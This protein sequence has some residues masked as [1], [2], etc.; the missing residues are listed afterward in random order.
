MPVTA[1][2]QAEYWEPAEEGFVLCRLCP[3]GCRI[4]PSS[5]G[6]CGARQ[7]L[8]GVL[9]AATYGVLSASHVD[10][11]EKKP[12]WHYYPGREILSVGSWGCNL[13]CRYC[14]NYHLSRETGDGPIVTPEV[15]AEQASRVP[16]NLGVAFTYNE[17]LIGFEYVR[18]CARQLRMRGLKSVLV[19]N[20]FLNREPLVGLVPLID[21]ANVDLKSRDDSFYRDLCSG[22]LAP[23]LAAL[24]LFHRHTH[25]E[26]TKLLVTGH[27]DPVDDAE[28]VA[29]T[30]ASEL[31][32]D[33]PLHLSRYFP[34][35]EWTAPETSEHML[36][37]ALER[38][39]RHLRYA[40]A[41][42][43][44][45]RE[46]SETRCPDCDRTLIRREGY[47]T[48]VVGLAPGGSCAGCG[49]KVPVLGV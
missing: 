30:I 4:A 2:H 7:N 6:R 29:E 35:H 20:G 21:A 28:R 11:I 5:F 17:P 33:V 36:A 37:G 32:P 49:R 43:T 26:V 24:R 13:A 25:L 27:G 10:P 40:Y 47:R 18:D 3:H 44:M 34:R 23:V 12:L 38:A 48:R 8:G 45:R 41:G 42:N 22:R 9:I 39:S 14:Q 16:G 1:G 46:G 15:L 19:T 31:S